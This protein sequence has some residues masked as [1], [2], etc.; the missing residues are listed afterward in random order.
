MANKENKGGVLKNSQVEQDLKAKGKPVNKD[1]AYQGAQD[2]GDKAVR[3][4]GNEV[5]QRD[6]LPNEENGEN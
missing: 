6:G 2:N 1:D 3:Q 5:Q 4:M